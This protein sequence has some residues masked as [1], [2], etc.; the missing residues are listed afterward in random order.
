MTIDLAGWALLAATVALS[1][2]TKVNPVWLIAG[3][4]AVGAVGL[5]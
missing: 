5:V 2:F 1:V 3:G 4:A